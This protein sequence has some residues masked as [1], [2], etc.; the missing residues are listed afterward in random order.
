MF[1]YSSG[2][3]EAQKLLFGYSVEGDVLDVSTAARQR[4]DRKLVSHSRLCLIVICCFL[5]LSSY[6]MVTLT[7]L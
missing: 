1:I 2:S 3:V 5:C 4:L 6:S 7:R